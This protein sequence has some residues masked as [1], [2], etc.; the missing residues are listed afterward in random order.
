MDFRELFFASLLQAPKGSLPERLLMIGEAAVSRYMDAC[1]VQ[2]SLRFRARYAGQLLANDLID[3]KGDLR[4]DRL[5]GWIALFDQGIYVLGPEREGDALIYG[6]LREALRAL[7]EKGGLWT[8]IRKF[9]PPLANKKA[10]ELVRITLWPEPIKTVQTT[11][12]RRA[13][14]AAW[15]T[16]L[17]QTT[18]SCFATA[19]AILIQMRH[20]LRLIRDLYDRLSMCMSKRVVVGKE[21]CVPYKSN[22]G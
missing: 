21:Y 9:S 5:D 8:W 10:E 14:L 18:G 17:R 6:H 20:P 1:P 15:F 11:H 3:E 4:K 12:V 13:V 19:P 2:D 7:K 16:L 22:F